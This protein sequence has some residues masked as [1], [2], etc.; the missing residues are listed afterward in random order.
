MGKTVLLKQA[1]EEK[2]QEIRYLK[3]LLRKNTYTANR[4]TRLASLIDNLDIAAL[5]EDENRK[6]LLTNQKFCDLFRLPGAPCQLEG[7]DC[8]DLAENTK[9]FFTN[10]ESF[11]RRINEL[12]SARKKALSDIVSMKDGRLFKRNFIPMFHGEDY[13]GHLW[14]YEDITQTI[15]VT[16]QIERISRLASES[17]N[18]IVRCTPE[19]R[20]LY[21]NAA[22]QPLTDA[23]NNQTPSEQNKTAQKTITEHIERAFLF[24]K[25]LKTEIIVHDKVFHLVFVPILN[26]QYVNIY[27]RDITDTKAA[28]NKIHL[29]K[30]LLDQFDEFIQVIDKDGNFIFANQA[31]ANRFGY[32]PEELCTKNIKDVVP[33]FHESKNWKKQFNFFK[34]KEKVLLEATHTRADQTVYPIETSIKYTEANGHEYLVS[35]SKDISERVENSN[36]LK[37]QKEFYEGILNHI[38]LDIAVFNSDYEYLYVNPA[39]IKDN[40]L[41]RWIIGKTDVDYCSYRKKNDSIAEER[42]KRYEEVFRH[43]KP[44]EWEDIIHDKEGHP[45][46]YLRRLQPVQDAQGHAKTIIGYGLNITE[47]KESEEKFQAIF[48]HSYDGKLLVDPVSNRILDCNQRTLELFE[49]RNKED[50][51]NQPTVYLRKTQLTSEE[52]ERRWEQLKTLG[53]WSQ[54]VLYTTQKG[55]EFWGSVVAKRIRINERVLGLVRI[56][57]ITEKKKNEEEL[58][59]AKLVAEESTRAKEVFLA[60][61]SHEIR[62]PVSG[63]LGMTDL[64]S[65]TSLDDTQK[66]Y[67]KL[68]KNTAGN[69][70]I[71]VNDILDLTKIESGKL[72]IEKI[73]F[74]ICEVVKNTMQSLMYK[75]EEKNIELTIHP[76]NIKN[77]VVV[78]DPFR[79][80]Q[81]LLN[82][83]NNAIKFTEKG[84][85][86]ISGKIPH[87]NAEE[88]TFEFTI[89]DTG[90]GIPK[91]KLESIFESF[92][93]ASSDTTRK[94]G[95]TGLGLTISKDLI[96]MQGGTIRV[97]STPGEGSKFTFSLTYKKGVSNSQSESAKKEISYKGLAQLRV[98]LAEDNEINQFLAKTLLSEW[99][100]EVDIADNG[101]D[102]FKLFEKNNYDLILMDIQMPQMGGIEVTAN[103][104][105]YANKQKASVSIIALTANALEGDAEKYQAAGMNGYLSKPFQREALYW[106]VYE[107]VKPQI[108]TPSGIS[109]NDHGTSYSNYLPDYKYLE[110]NFNNNTLFLKKIL[111]IFVETTP[112]MV[113]NLLVSFKEKDYTKLQAVAHKLKTSVDSFRIKPLQEIIRKIETY[114]AERTHLNELPSLIQKVSE[115]TEAV[116]NDIRRKLDQYESCPVHHQN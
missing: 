7:S 98:L 88:I 37:N 78:G 11:V 105:N 16:K 40:E 81:V 33:A 23:F 2:D 69:L 74:D 80:T 53:Y 50:L 5:L 41:R 22:A 12:V 20:L 10:S 72:S 46:H 95:G 103:I 109:N 102:A 68:I 60:N 52:I 32:S 48:D 61:T 93:Q 62:T 84:S 66:H 45:I 26:E 21:A 96:Q 99:G 54:E 92:T 29:L 101:I 28:E 44:V 91:E 112:S 76:L 36:A 58:I 65:K 35:F 104:R 30:Q 56:T 38:P 87:A 8:S 111:T 9:Q 116:Q 106:K 51:I 27:G 108:D 14:T 90:I 83:I 24:G 85:V 19:G 34:E 94:Y 59:Q 25:I 4:S 77:V 55:N 15:N 89:Q 64:L 13:L 79:L 97:E 110:K 86:E 1:L 114:S 63:I 31:S 57:D 107:H 82:L 47:I 73:P 75:A 67:L 100:A 113:E 115:I 71:I 49:V 18:P 43:N 6:L 42:I 3:E 39:A 70:L 17:P